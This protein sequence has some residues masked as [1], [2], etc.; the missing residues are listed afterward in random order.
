MKFFVDKD[1]NKNSLSFQLTGIRGKIPKLKDKKVLNFSLTRTGQK[2]K[3]QM[4]EPIETVIIRAQQIFEIA[5][6]LNLVQIEIEDDRVLN[7]FKKYKNVLY[8]L[9]P[10]GILFP[11][12]VKN[13][14][15]QIFITCRKVNNVKKFLIASKI[16]D[17]SRIIDPKKINNWDEIKSQ[18][19]WINTTLE[20]QKKINNSRHLCFHF[21]T[22][23]LNDLLSFSTYLI[24]DKNEE[25]TCE[26]NE[27]KISILNFKIDVFLWWIEI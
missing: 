24:D 17:L 10:I 13:N 4:T 23:T 21:S 27:K 18:S 15:E 9:T 11:A 1:K 14:T 6:G 7:I 26:N 19:I 8:R 12:S 5:W 2:R 22:K 20:E 25:I 16:Y 3:R